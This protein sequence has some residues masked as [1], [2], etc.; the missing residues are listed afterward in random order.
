VFW[1]EIL[2]S[3]HN[4]RRKEFLVDFGKSGQKENM[5]RCLW[6]FLRGRESDQTKI[7]LFWFEILPSE[8]NDRRK[9]FLVNFIMRL[10]VGQK[11]NMPGRW[12]CFEQYNPRV[13]SCAEE[14]GM[15]GVLDRRR[16]VFQDLL[17]QAT[18]QTSDDKSGV[19]MAFIHDLRAGKKNQ[20]CLAQLG[21]FGQKKR[22]IPRFFEPRR[23]NKH[24]LGCSRFWRRYFR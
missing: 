21:C 17:A 19:L 9:E 18:E 2:P 14:P 5:D 3:E 10:K 6:A 22:R 16:G 7:V 20:A 8:H 4:D 13:E 23:Q 24:K 11:K 1:F 12:K 15:S